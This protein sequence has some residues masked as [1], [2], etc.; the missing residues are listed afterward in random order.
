MFL[1]WI[2]KFKPPFAEYPVSHTRTILNEGHN[3]VRLKVRGE[4][5]IG[6]EKKFVVDIKFDENLAG[7]AKLSKYGMNLYENDEQFFI[8]YVTFASQAE[9]D[10]LAF[11]FEI[12]NLFLAQE[13]PGKNSCIYSS[14]NYT[15]FYCIISIFTS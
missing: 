8:D 12:T 3:E 11:D 7:N 14:I 15:S 13:Q 2:N 6:D 4:D 1:L 5:F 10:G 9:K